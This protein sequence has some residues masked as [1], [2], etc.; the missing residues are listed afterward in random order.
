M[1]IHKY[2]PFHEQIAVDLPDRTWPTKRI[3]KARAGAPWT[4]A[5]A[6][7]RSSIR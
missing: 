3:E 7:R 1:P 5:T 4:S 6:T 2:V